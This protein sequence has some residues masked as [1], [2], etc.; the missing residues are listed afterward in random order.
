M[1]MKRESVRTVATHE[2]G[3]R[4]YDVIRTAWVGTDGL[5]FDVEDA[6][7]GQLLTP[8]SWDTEPLK[9]DIEYLLCELRDRLKDGD[10]DSFFSGSENEL[11]EIL[12]A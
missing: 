7:T 4:K 8:E 3:G 6:A 2:I 9:I 11:R 5:S 1:G 10:L 12:G